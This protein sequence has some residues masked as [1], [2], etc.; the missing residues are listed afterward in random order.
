[1]LAADELLAR[2]YKKKYLAFRRPFK[3]IPKRN[4][5]FEKEWIYKNDYSKVFNM[6]FNT[7]EFYS[8]T[9]N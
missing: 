3:T 2:Q 4:F 7:D 5:T 8:F 9:V 1:M 6:S